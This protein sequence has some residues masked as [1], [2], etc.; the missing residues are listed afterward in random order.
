MISVFLPCTPN[1]TTGFYFYVPIKDV[2]E[3]AITP[4]EAAQ[5]VMSAG[6]IQPTRTAAVKSLAEAVRAAQTPAR[7]G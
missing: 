4:N 6:L 1:P 7:A 2:I 5:L 3:V